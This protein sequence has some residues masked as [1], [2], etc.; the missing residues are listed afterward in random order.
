MKVRE[1]RREE[2]KEIRE[3]DRCEIVEQIYYYQ[4]GN[5]VLKDEYYEIK[6]WIPEELEEHIKDLSD[7]Y[8]QGGFFIGAFINHKLVG[9]IALGCEFIGSRKDQLQMVFL[10]VDHNYRDK[11][12]G[13]KLMNF[14]IKKAK[15]LGAKK[16]Y[17]SA[18]PSKHTVDFYMGLGCKLASEINQEL[19]QLEPDDIHLEL[20]I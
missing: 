7:L 1:I 15:K 6:G 8:D 20:L 5:I 13:T 3:L 10:H 9:I 14:V 12:L 17:I 16:L 19:F 2:I 4:N 18:T 11:G